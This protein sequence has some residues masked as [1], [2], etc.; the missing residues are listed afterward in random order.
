MKNV[1]GLKKIGEYSGLERYICKRNNG[2]WVQFFLSVKD[3]IVFSSKI[4][5]PAGSRY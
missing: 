1:G 5:L 3:K 4:E 2:D